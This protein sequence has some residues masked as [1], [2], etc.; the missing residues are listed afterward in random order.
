MTG[1]RK[2]TSA[3][4]R[5]EDGLQLAEYVLLTVII[6]VGAIVGMT[7]LGQGTSNKMNNMSDTIAT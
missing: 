1:L 7:A 5:D 6:G 3:L 4:Y 2:L